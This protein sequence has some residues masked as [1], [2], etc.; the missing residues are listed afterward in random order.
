MK[1][2]YAKL[3]TILRFLKFT[4]ANFFLTYTQPRLLL[5]GTINLSSKYFTA[6]YIYIQITNFIPNFSIVL[7]FN[8]YERL[9]V[10]TRETWYIQHY[11]TIAI[12]NHQLD[13]NF[14]AFLAYE[15]QVEE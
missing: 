3:C 14:R 7:Q 6:R 4:A 15:F 8:I 9:S 2:T 1:T 5:V 10:L 11:F 13:C 12:S